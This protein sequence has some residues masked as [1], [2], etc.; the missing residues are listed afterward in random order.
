MLHLKPRRFAWM[1]VWLV[2]GFVAGGWGVARG[3]DYEAT[4]APL[5]SRYCGKCHGA[6]KPKGKLNLA[7]FADMDSV[8]KSRK[9]W[10]RVLEQVESEVMP[11][12]GADAPTAEERAR[13]VAWAQATFS[14]ADCDIE[15]PGRVTMRRLNRAEYNNTIR[16]LFQ[17]DMRPADEFPYDDVGYGFDTIG[18][19]LMLPPMLMEKYM[20]A[21]ERISER[22]IVTPRVFDGVVGNWQATQ[23]E[24]E[25]GDAEG[26]RRLASVG[27]L[28]FVVKFPEKGRYRLRVTAYGEQAGGEPVKMALKLDGATPK[29]VDVKS[30]AGSPGTYEFEIAS[31]QPGER[32]I[33]LEFLN[34]F[35]NEQASDPAQRDRNLVI[36][37]ARLLGAPSAPMW[38]LA[39]FGWSELE[40]GSADESGKHRTLASNGEIFKEIEAPEDGVYRVEVRAFEAEAG[41]EPAKMA[42]LIDGRRIRVDDVNQK[43]N[44][45]GTFAV[46]VPLMKG[47]HRLAVAFVNDYYEPD[48][49]DAK[50][51]GDR[52]LHVQEMEVLATSARG[53][54]ESHRRVI[55]RAPR[56]AEEWAA[57]TRE[58]L[59]AFLLR[60]YRR[61]ATPRELDRLCALVEVGRKNGESYEAA[62]RL[63]VQAALIN[64]SFLYRVEYERKSRPSASSEPA[65]VRLLDDFELATRLSYF[66]W[67]SLPDDELLAVAAR[68]GLQDEATLEKQVRRM[69][70]DE[71]AR[72]LVDNFASQ[73]LQIRNLENMSPDARRFKDFDRALL[74][75]MKR[76][77]DA[78]IWFIVHEDR[79]ARELLSSDYTFLNERLAKHYGIGGVSGGEFRRVELGADSERGGLLTQG[80]VLT[81]TSNPTRTSPVKR[82]KWILEQ[83]LG[84][85][86]P[87]PPPDVPALK[88]DRKSRAAASLRQRFE[89]HRANPSCAACH[90]KMDPLGFTFEHFDAVGAWRDKDGE[91]AVDAKGTLPGGRALAGARELKR[92][93]REEESDKFVR[94]LCE[95][96][97]IYGLGRGLESYDACNIDEVTKRVSADGYRFSRIV[98]EIVK[99]DPFRKRSREEVP[100][101]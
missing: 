6:E 52:N 51:R 34:D 17:I 30:E 21:A 56:K 80:S 18:D 77:T 68:K 44:S 82:G 14:K 100:A 57:C 15:Q 73:W 74:G 43:W 94:T 91:F 40:G 22:V 90:A 48:A 1:W 28:S 50:D 2:A 88:D 97:L 71:K 67:S 61:P 38:P 60:A 12:E 35:F 11:P 93:L 47:K 85:P 7:A 3:D 84:T 24:G 4:I 9:V 53:L 37:S 45:P 83:V 54:P 69:L 59:Q 36:M 46:T 70:K 63:A 65:A 64:P 25:A 95:K 13:I 42:W 92:Y 101:S 41:R 32:R 29:K 86:P 76:E 66:L 23:M 55:G 31:K 27:A 78:F 5:L 39:R 96:L 26:G 89:E 8:L 20:T 98:V 87:A 58:N 99:S 81:V 10:E 72:A 16:D 49:G 33:S 19:V 75:D 62:M 79:D